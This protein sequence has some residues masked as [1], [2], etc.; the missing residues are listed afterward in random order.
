MVVA[1]LAVPDRTIPLAIETPKHTIRHKVA[2]V[3]KQ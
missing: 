3:W 1:F 2:T